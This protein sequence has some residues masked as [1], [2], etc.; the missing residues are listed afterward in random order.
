MKKIV[1]AALVASMVAG[2]AFAVDAKITLN[3]RTKLDAF[4]QTKESGAKSAT[5]TEWLD[6]EGYDGAGKQKA[7][8]SADTFKFVLNG[9]KAGATFAA[10]INTNDSTYTLNQYSAW[11][12]WELGP[13]ELKLE[14][15]NWKDGYVDNA[16]RVKKDV[17]SQNAEGQDFE[18]FKLGSIFKGSKALSFVDDLAA[19]GNNK[20]LFSC[21]DYGFSTDSDMKINVLL[22]SVYN[23]FDTVVDGD[24]TT[25]YDAFFVSRVQVKVPELLDGELIFKKPAP[26]VNTFG[27][28]VMPKVLDG[29][30]LN[31]G[32]SM[33][34]DNRSK[35]DGGYT[36]WGFDLRARYQATDELSLTLFTNLSGT[37]LEAG[38]KISA[39]V[40]GR[41]GAEGWATTSSFKTA[42]WNNL[43]A[44]Y[45]VSDLLAVTLNVGLITPLGKVSGDDEKYSPEW[46]VTPAVQVYAAKNASIWGGLAISGS[47]VKDA[48]RSVTSIQV[49]VIFRVKM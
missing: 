11:M 41:K 12:K 38:R 19:G 28:Y 23:A 22:G 32:G 25:Y 33:E 26:H 48:D 20:A 39:G 4:S 24:K 49:P 31:V 46:R 37:N 5:T 43:S 1:S 9:E 29:L 40:V 7:T 30:T 27:L 2:A 34:M 42:M 18:R 47:S 3:Y 10:N 17:D 35:D 36:D 21:A 14:S 16:Y 8:N 6:W 45:A 44:R 13:G 15:G